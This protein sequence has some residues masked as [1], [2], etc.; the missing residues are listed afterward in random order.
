MTIRQLSEYLQKLEATTLRNEMTEVLAQLIREA[1]SWE[2]EKISYLV[3]GRLGPLYESIQF[4]LADKMMTRVLAQISGKSEAEIKRYY[5][6]SGDLGEVAAYCRKGK[7]TG[8]KLAVG[9]VFERLLAV[10]AE[11]GEGSVERKIT[12]LAGLLK[13]LDKISAKY[14][15]RITLGK[16]RLGFSD[17]TF[18]DALSWSKTEDKSLREEIERAYNICPDIGKVAYVLKTKGVRGLAKIRARPGV[19][20]RTA[21]AERLPSAE[22]IMEKLGKV[23]VEPKMDGVRIQ[24][25]LDSGRRFEVAGQLSFEAFDLSGAFVKLFSRN[26]EE[27]TAMFPDVVEKLQELASQ[28]GIKSAIFDSEAIT[29]DPESEGFLPFQETARRKRKYEVEKKAKEL[30]LK[31]FLFDLLYLDGRTLLDQ[32]FAKRRKLLEKMV[33]KGNE[34]IML[35][36]QEVVGKAEELH[37]LF[38]LY[39][40]EGLEG[41]MCKKLDSTYQ[42]GARNFNWVKYKRATEGGLMDTLDGVVLGYYRGTG[43]RAG[44]GIGA[45]LV[46]IYDEKNNTF[47]TIAK[48]GTGLTDEQWEEMRQRCDEMAVKK[49]DPRYIFDKHL[50]CDVWVAPRLVVE[51]KADEITRS[52]VHMAGKGVRLEGG[53]GRAKDKESGLALRF[54]RLI[55]FREKRPEIAT[56]LKETLKLYQL[57]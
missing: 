11:S 24:G 41:V 56:T 3:M 14:V 13:E 28:T 42:A 29:Y 50:A 7:K 25:H 9:E 37:R 39:I 44:F 10:A 1:K 53:E 27:T 34:V 54:P 23:A 2:I 57:Q 19:P 20:I 33:G 12:V 8:R 48:I 45:F 46:G 40:S 47:P 32:P 49:P 36:R 18:L 22:K 30:P 52:P 31:V 15:V 5:K 4:N 6:Q 21:Q 16:L 55:R 43:K 35:V 38:D 51:I 17:L 26:L